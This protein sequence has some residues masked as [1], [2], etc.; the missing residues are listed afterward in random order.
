MN[1]AL[2]VR[3]LAGADFFVIAALIIGF[4]ADFGFAAAPFFAATFFAGDFFAVAILNSPSV[5][6]GC[7]GSIGALNAHGTSPGASVGDGNAS[8]EA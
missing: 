8:R 7:T 5:C 3:F 6:C 1:D 4:D 2:G